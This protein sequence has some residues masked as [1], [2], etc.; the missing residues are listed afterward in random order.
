[1]AHN[2]PKWPK[3]DARIYTLFPQFFFDW[4][5][6]SANF[7]AFRMYVEKL[8][9]SHR[10]YCL[11][12]FRLKSVFWQIWL[13]G[14]VSPG[15]CDLRGNSVES[16][17]NERISRRQNGSSWLVEHLSWNQSDGGGIL[18]EDFSPGIGWANT[19]PRTIGAKLMFRAVLLLFNYTLSGV[20]FEI[21][22][23]PSSLS[24]QEHKFFKR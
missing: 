12:I 16:P 13:W 7:F 8:T 4:K 18:W 22:P 24:K 19:L 1:M 20:L 3:N 2:Y 11:D 17:G 21:S 15:N 23:P 9:K 5:S 10:K 14:A 6:G